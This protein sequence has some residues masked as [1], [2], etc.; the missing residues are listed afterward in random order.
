MISVKVSYTVKPEFAAQNK[1]NINTFLTDFKQ[2]KQL[3]FLYNVYLQ[4]DGLTFLHMSMYENE[5]VQQ[6]ILSTPSF[7]TFQ[8]QRDESG[9]TIQPKIEL[10]SLI[11][12]SLSPLV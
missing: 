9:L 10:I 5:E 8:Q 4:D 12:S 2:L 1:Q 11:G 6:T 7:L 3:K